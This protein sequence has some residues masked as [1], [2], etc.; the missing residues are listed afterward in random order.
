MERSAF[1]M[2]SYRGG[3]LWCLREREGTYITFSG[4]RIARGEDG[5]W[6]VLQDG[7]KVDAVGPA[8]VHVRYDDNAGIVL[9][10]RGG[11]SPKGAAPQ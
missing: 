11:G 5:T 1:N 8:A 7:W 6:M 3:A 9:A 4:L 10:F 2:G